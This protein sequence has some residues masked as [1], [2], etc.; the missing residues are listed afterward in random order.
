MRRNNARI[1]SLFLA[2]CALLVITLACNLSSAPQ[3]P[4][5]PAPG[6]VTGSATASQPEPAQAPTD[7][8]NLENPPIEETSPPDDNESTDGENSGSGS[9]SETEEEGSS[10]LVD[11]DLRDSVSIKNGN[12]SYEGNISFPGSATSVAITIKPIDFDNAQSSGKLVFTLTCSGR[13]RAK[14]NYKG[15]AIREGVPG[16]DETWT[17]HVSDSSPD[18][19]ISIRLDASGDVDWTLHV[20]GGE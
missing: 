3:E 13:G 16:C 18:S 20:T 11:A 6:A 19:H 12:K 2:G 8:G 17:A 4:T 7:S 15:A 9:S 14:V 10:T 1:P 5:A